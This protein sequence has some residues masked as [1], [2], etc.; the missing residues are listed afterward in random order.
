M[1]KAWISAA[2][3]L[4]SA[5]AAVATCFYLQRLPEVLIPILRCSPLLAG[6]VCA[7]LSP[8]YK[9]RSGFLV[10]IAATLLE[11]TL[12]LVS[13][14]F[15]AQVDLPGWRGAWVAVE[16]AMIFNTLYAMTG[17]LIG[18]GLCHWVAPRERVAS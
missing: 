1:L 2:V 16:L 5:Q 6:L 8:R 17:S 4:I 7:L 3:I 12:N 11:V 10:G 15:G 18:Y 13:Q 14:A 9:V